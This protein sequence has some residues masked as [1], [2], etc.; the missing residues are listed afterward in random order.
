[1]ER[2]LSGQQSQAYVHVG[3]AVSV[4]VAAVWNRIG[5]S[6]VQPLFFLVFYLHS[7]PPLFFFVFFSSF[8]CYHSVTGARMSLCV[9][10][11]GPGCGD[12]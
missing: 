4:Y 6:V 9:M 8:H 7:I 11:H 1:M 2:L 5:K 3:H 10:V 12:C